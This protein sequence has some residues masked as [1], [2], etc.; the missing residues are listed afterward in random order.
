MITVEEFLDQEEHYSVSSDFDT[1][2]AMIQFAKMH[3]R[4]ALEVASENAIIINGRYAEDYKINKDS[5]LTAY[6]LENIK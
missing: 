4:K 3:V 2:Y 1:H 6:P 5:I